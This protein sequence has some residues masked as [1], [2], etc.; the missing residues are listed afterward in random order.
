MFITF[1]DYL[2]V[3]FRYLRLALSYRLNSHTF[4]AYRRLYRL[5]FLIGFTYVS[6]FLSYWRMHRWCTWRCLVSH[7]ASVSSIHQLAVAVAWFL[8]T[9]VRLPTDL[10][11][12]V[13]YLIS[14]E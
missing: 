11:F 5:V 3:F 13:L 7:R 8:N 10:T 6:S 1:D 4:A 12:C 14:F 9:Q 2:N